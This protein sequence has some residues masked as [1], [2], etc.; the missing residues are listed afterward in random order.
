MS[1]TRILAWAGFLL[2]FVFVSAFTVYAQT[3]ILNV[4][5][6]VARELYKDVNPVAVHS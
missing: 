2:A 4:S 6:D 5:Y 3:T 1:H